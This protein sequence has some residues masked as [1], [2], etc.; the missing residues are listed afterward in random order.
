MINKK[1]KFL[2]VGFGGMGC[3]HA[4]SLINSF[5]G[6]LTYI[7]EPNDDIFKKNIKLIGQNK[8]KDV[9]RLS[10]LS[11]SNDKIDLCVI[12]TSAGPRFDILK[13]LLHY[14]ISYFLLEKV[15]FQSDYQ[16]E[17]ILKISS[18]KNI[19]VN[20]VNRYFKNYIQI[21]EE[22]NNEPFS[23]NIISGD[24]GLGSNSL[25]YFD[26]FKYFGG[27]KLKLNNYVL[28]ENING[29]KRGNEYK[30][31]LGQI[32]IKSFEDS[33]LNISS[34]SLR[35]GGVEITI[36]HSNK[37]HVI[38]EQLL[39]HMEFGVN[40][41]KISPLHVEYTSS[42]TGKIFKDILDSKC[43][44][45]KL[46]DTKDIHSILFECVNKSLNLKTEDICPVT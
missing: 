2:I 6:C 11:K 25:H 39:N 8:N 45:P 3:R 21:K 43:L 16:F 35:E 34:D 10:K 27:S 7:F 1:R 37:T 29:N 42:L 13:E 44:L 9:I 41:I 31:I 17:E 23:V 15:V 28:T 18:G 33:I 32:S 40:E 14:N 19:Y 38:N 24:F 22:I 20:F 46:D 26:L 30:E 5:Q 12:A 4:Q 36:Q